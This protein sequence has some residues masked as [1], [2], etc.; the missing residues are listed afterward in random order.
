MPIEFNFFL[1]LQKFFSFLAGLI[2]LMPQIGSLKGEHGKNSCSCG[3]CWEKPEFSLVTGL[4]IVG[5]E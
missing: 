3:K 2:A 1:L 5:Y 4:G